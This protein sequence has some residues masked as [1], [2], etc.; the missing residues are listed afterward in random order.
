LLRIPPR[1]LYAAFDRF[2]SRKGAAIHIDRFARTLFAA[3]SGGLLYVLGGEGLPAYQH[4][5]TIEIVRFSLPVENY[6]ARAL[7]FGAS[8]EPLLDEAGSELALCH[9]RDPWAGVP[10]V[11]RPHRYACVYEVNGL[12]SIELPQVYP[13]L[14]NRTLDKIRADEQLCWTVADRVITPA[15]TIAQNLVRLGC[16]AA[17]IVT[18]PNGADIRPRPPRAPDMPASY[19]LYLGALQPWQGFEVLLRAFGRLG[20]FPDLRLVVCVSHASRAMVRYQ[21][22]AE[23]LGLAERMVWRTALEETEL[24]PIRA[25]ALVSVAPLRECVRNLSQGCAPLKILES[26][27]DG[28][29]VVA[30]DLPAVREI[31]TDGHDGRLVPADRPADLA[32]ALRILLEYPELRERLGTN[33]RTTVENRLTWDLS[34]RR[35][36]DEVY[37]ELLGKG[38]QL[39]TGNTVVQKVA[40]GA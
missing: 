29:A 24:A 22:M 10:I 18:I 31:I 40:P 39:E 4:E 3:S 15:A 14:D 21:R 11:S 16:P 17:K 36:R 12:P 2:P 9:F 38:N 26:M 5:G 27:A 25:H 19:I 23:N 33:A 28:V 8:L 6:L 7:A 34:L 1:A 20:D 30:S 37:R 13:D 35:L 32:R